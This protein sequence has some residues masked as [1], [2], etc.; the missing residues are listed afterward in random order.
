MKTISVVIYT[1]FNMMRLANM[2]ILNKYNYIATNKLKCKKATNIKTDTYKDRKKLVLTLKLN[3]EEL[4]PNY[5][6]WFNSKKKDASDC[7]TAKYIIWKNFKDYVI[8]KF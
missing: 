1:Y 3:I 7:A 8:S 6:T 2:E 4:F 5:L